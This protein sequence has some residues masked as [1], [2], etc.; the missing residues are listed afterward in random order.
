MFLLKK[1]KLL[2]MAFDIFSF[3]VWFWMVL[4]FLTKERFVL[5]E[6]IPTFYLLI[7]ASYVGDKE[8]R[9]WRKK[10]SSRWR[11]G[12]YFVYLWGLTLVA[13]VAWC[14]WQGNGQ[15]YLIPHNLPVVAGSVLILYIFT[16]YVKENTQKRKAK[17][18]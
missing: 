16:E 8:L 15:G 10:Y 7:L 14:N 4:E 18:H 1:D 2:L 5:P 11:K 12:E 17:I 3:I 13:I 6:L 9:R